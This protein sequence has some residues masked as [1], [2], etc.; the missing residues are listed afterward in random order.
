MY[1][2]LS[3][4]GRM[5]KELSSNSAASLG[6]LLPSLKLGATPLVVG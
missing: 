3:T 1:F 2:G 4:T 5:T 6:G